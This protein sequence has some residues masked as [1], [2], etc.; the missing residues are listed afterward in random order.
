MKR[1]MFGAVAALV[2]SAAGASAQQLPVQTVAE[3]GEG[4]GLLSSVREL[5]DGRVLVADPLGQFLAA[6]DM[7]SG[8]MDIWGREGGGPQEYRQ[9]DAVWPLPDGKSLLVDLGNG[10]LILVGA[11]GSFEDTTPIAFGGGPGQ[12]GR[13]QPP[14]MV[15]PSDVDGSGRIYF[16]QR[17]FRNPGDSSVVASVRFGEEGVEQ[18]GR[19]KPQDVTQSGGGGNVQI[20]PVPMSPQDGWAVADDGRMVYVRAD[21]ADGYVVQVVQPDGSVIRSR[22]REIEALRPTDD[23]KYAYLDL[24]SSSGIQVSMSIN[25]GA[26]Q[27]SFGRGGGGGGQPDLRQYE[28]PDRMPL[29]RSGTVQVSPDGR[30]FVG[31]TVHAGDPSLFDVFDMSARFLGTAS[32]DP[33]SSIVGFGV[34]GAIYV[35]SVDDFGLQWLKKVRVG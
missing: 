18:H 28:W 2:L 20:A 16:T 12:G 4:F 13:P 6:L 22:P 5:P 31:R 7:D 23:D 32:F 15:L 34:D 26:R 33:N 25:N 27:M 11:D 17:S 8:D 14:S 19:V 3:Y 35:V 21:G 10:R 1:V 24:Q 30:I 29:F 9:P